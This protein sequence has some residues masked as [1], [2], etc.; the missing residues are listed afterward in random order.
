MLDEDEPNL[1]HLSG[2]KLGI[3]ILVL[4]IFIVIVT[5]VIYFVYKRYKGK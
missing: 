4:A 2:W 3:T 5:I 1:D